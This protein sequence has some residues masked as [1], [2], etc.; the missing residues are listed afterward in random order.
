[1]IVGSDPPPMPGDPPVRALRTIV[2]GSAVANCLRFPRFRPCFR[3]PGPFYDRS[4]LTLE[5]PSQMDRFL[6]LVIG[7]WWIPGLIMSV[8]WGLRGRDLFPNKDHSRWEAF[9]QITFNSVGSFAGWCCIYALAVRMRI[10]LPSSHNLLTGCAPS[11]SGLIGPAQSFP[12]LTGGDFLLFLMSVLGATGHLP[13]AMAGLLSSIERL[14]GE[15]QRRSLAG[16]SLS[17]MHARRRSRVRP[18]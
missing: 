17:A 13:Q 4:R 8:L 1:M 12:S 2:P 9:Y 6:D 7:Y 5:R 16:R 10:A 3:Y 11:A 14:V 18:P 15:P